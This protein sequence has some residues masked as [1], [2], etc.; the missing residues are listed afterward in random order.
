M[1]GRGRVALVLLLLGGAGAVYAWWRARREVA[2]GPLRL[3]GNVDLRQVELAFQASERIAA[4]LVEEGDRV[5]KGQV[6][7]RLD[8]SRLAPRAAEAAAQAAALRQVVTR[9]RNGSRPEEIARA[10]AE[11]EAAQADAAD[12]RT[13]A[14]RLARLPEGAVSQLD[15]DAAQAAMDAAQ[16]RLV[17]GQRALDLVLAGPRAEEVAEAEARLSAAEATAALARAELD[18]AT[19]VSPTAGVVRARLLE[20]GELASPGRPVVSLAVTDPKWVRAYV[21]EPDLPV[22][23]PGMPA[24]VEA[25]G[26]GG[27]RLRGWVGFVSPVAEFTPKTVQTEELRT[28]LVYEVRVYVTDPDDLLRLGMP[29]TV[30]LSPGATSTAAPRVEAAAVVSGTIAPAASHAP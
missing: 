23:H 18:E 13:R 17:A 5:A 22:V 20:P 11:V 12:A 6:V 9:L 8:T 7:A 21:S 2:G 29:A 10:R 15:R 26:L 25:D 19:L 4:V 24:E 14:G 1:S 3:Q 28:S 27:R 30:V 16:A